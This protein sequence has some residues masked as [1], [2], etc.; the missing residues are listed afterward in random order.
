MKVPMGVDSTPLRWPTAWKDPGMLSLLQATQI[1]YL[2]LDPGA[3]GLAEHARRAGLTVIEPE[4]LPS[5]VAVVRGPWPGIRISHRG[6]DRAAAGPTGEPWVDSNGWRVRAA[7]ALRPDAQFW[8][9]AKP[10]P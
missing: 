4:A 10:Q 2:I 6:G 5:G 9:D 8:V 1:R 7:R 3:G